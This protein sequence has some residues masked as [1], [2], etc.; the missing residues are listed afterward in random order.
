MNPN[1]DARPR[2]AILAAALAAP[3]VLATGTAS[4][5]SSTKK[6]KPGMTQAPLRANVGTFTSAARKARGEGISVYDVNPATG[7]FTHR[8]TLGDLVNPSFLVTSRD[9]RFLYAVHGDGE[10]ATAFAID[11]ATGLIRLLN[12]GA[13]GGKNGVRQAIDPTGRWMPVAN[14]GTGSVAVLP[15]RADGT[16]GD[17]Q[18]LVELP[19]KPGP[20]K[21]EQTVSHPHDVVFDPS[22]K[23]FVVPDKGLDRVFVF[24][25]DP[26]TGRIAPAG[27][28][29]VVQARAAG[30]S[31]GHALTGFAPGRQPGLVPVHRH[32]HPL[33]TG[34]AR[35]LSR[36]RTVGLPSS[37]TSKSCVATSSLVSVA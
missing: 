6:A 23:F 29:G 9:Q 13:T 2:R 17:Q 35:R 10:Q 14:Y 27:H 30:N 25:L 4:A 19:G 7:A 15:V 5:Q 26:A 18:Q 36:T 28:G 24:A 1:H 16:L 34:L 37:V 8:Q 31:R 20:H 33:R 12:T 22:G 11:P 3:A 32:I 21:T